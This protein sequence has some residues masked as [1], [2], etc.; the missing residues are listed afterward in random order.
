MEKIT[1]N[2]YAKEGCPKCEVL[3]TIC[4]NSK[5]ILE[6]DFQICDIEKDPI[7]LELLK[8]NN[9][10]SLPVLLIENTFYTFN[11]AITYIRTMDGE[12]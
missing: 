8:E 3:E 9:I 1:I 11:E 7:Y 5:F 4:K 2:L 6:N 10:V 12:K